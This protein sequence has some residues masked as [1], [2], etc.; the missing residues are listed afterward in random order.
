MI[1]LFENQG[2]SQDAFN[3]LVEKR[4]REK[5]REVVPPPP[6]NK[7]NISD[8]VDTGPVDVG[9]ILHG[10]REI[11]DSMQA[12]QIGLTDVIREVVNEHSQY[13]GFEYT[14]NF[15][16][17]NGVMHVPGENQWVLD[18][19]WYAAKL[20][21]DVAVKAYE[22]FSMLPKPAQNYTLM[23]AGAIMM[24][25]GFYLSGAIVAL[26]GYGRHCMDQQNEA[27]QP[28]SGS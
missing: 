6:S 24:L 26:A 18:T 10:A 7:I 9:A 15:P 4:A 21:K 14:G 27:P 8:V 23:A 25:S 28:T 11:S 22:L 16:V 12:S 2:T 17:K 19:L 13:Q 20:V 1:K 5:A 3:V